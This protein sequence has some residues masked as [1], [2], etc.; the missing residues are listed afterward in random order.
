MRFSRMQDSAFFF[1]KGDPGELYQIAV[2]PVYLDASRGLDLGTVLSLPVASLN[3]RAAAVARANLLHTK[4]A[5]M[6]S[7]GQ[8]KYAGRRQPL[9]GISGNKVA[10]VLILGSFVDAGRRIAELSTMILRLWLGAMC[11][12]VALTYLLARRILE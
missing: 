2:T 1:Q 5:G 6:V 7:D 10:E 12:G 8:H 3:P 4:G 9:R 11:A